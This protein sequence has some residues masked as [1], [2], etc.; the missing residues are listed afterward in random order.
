MRIMVACGG[1]GGHIFPGLA[2]A[3]EL[4]ARG[5]DVTILLAG[6]QVEQTALAGWDGPVLTV[7]ARGLGVRRPG[8]ALAAVGRMLLACRQWRRLMRPAPPDVL[9]AMGSYASGGPV[10]AARSLGV[11]VVLH[12]ANVIPGR[13]VRWLSPWAQAVALGFDEARAHLR[14]PRL[15]LTGIPLRA[16]RPDASPDPRLAALTSGVFTLLVMGGSAGARCLNEMLPAAVRE[17]CRQGRRLQVIHLAG[18]AA[19]PAVAELYRQTP[20]LAA[21]VYPFL[22]DMP[23][24]YQRTNLAVCRAGAATCAE[25]LQFGVPALLVPYPYAANDHQAANAA[26][27]QK[28]GAGDMLREANASSGCLAD[29]IAQAMDQPERLAQMRAAAAA[30][31]LPDAAARVADLVQE[32]ARRRAVK[33]DGSEA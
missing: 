27:M 5:A 9:L 18:A 30:R 20:G 13:A 1:T 15:E 16:R 25:L 19:A 11:P 22:H 24:A 4:R 32:V 33:T 12:E 26:A 17:L 28:Y 10:W 6:K 21:A 23:Q 14:H 3:A 2:V 7:A 31:A 29:Y 8:A